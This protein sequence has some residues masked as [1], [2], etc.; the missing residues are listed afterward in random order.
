VSGFGTVFISY[1][2][3]DSVDIS[4]RLYDRL[5]REFGEGRVF[6]DLTS[7]DAGSTFRES[8]HHAIRNSSVM[9][10]IIG[11]AWDLRRL[12]EPDDL[13]RFEIGSALGHNLRVIPVLVAGAEMPPPTQLPVDIRALCDRNAV[14]LYSENFQVSADRLVRQLRQPTRIG[15]IPPQWDTEPAAGTRESPTTQRSGGVR[16]PP[17]WSQP[18]Q[19]GE[20][21]ASPARP[22]ESGY[23]IPTYPSLPEAALP[24]QRGRLGVAVTVL[25]GFSAGIIGVGGF[26]YPGYFLDRV[27]D[28]VAAQTGVQKVLT[29]DYGLTGVEQVVCPRSI[30]VVAGTSFTCRATLSGEQVEVR[31]EFITD[32]GDYAVSRPTPG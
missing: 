8:I 9:L 5:V 16:H 14:R 2:R 13:V 29:N 31:V 20:L 27:L 4:G 26:V 30:A 25:T 23:G 32:D 19:R 7:I 22:A 15:A 6:M 28:P 21:A 11:K 1:R 24:R 18:D 12:G 10:V 3:K 17:A